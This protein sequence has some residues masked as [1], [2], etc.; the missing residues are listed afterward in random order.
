MTPL[1]GVGGEED[2]GVRGIPIPSSDSRD[3]EDPDRSRGGATK[4]SCPRDATRWCLF[5]PVEVDGCRTLTGV[6]GGVAMV[7][8]EA[9]TG[10]SKEYWSKKGLKFS[11]ISSSLIPR[12]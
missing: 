9:M 4:V 1:G 10:D 12:S 6:A 8:V 11:M 7:E 3:E 2:L 5:V